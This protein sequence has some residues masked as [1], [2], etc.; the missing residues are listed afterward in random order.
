M[1]KQ[2]LTKKL[3]LNKE[4]IRV[5]TENELKVVAGATAGNGCGTNTCNTCL[6]TYPC[7]TNIV[8]PI[9]TTTMA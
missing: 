4:T 5:L 7:Y 8:E 2:E 3:T 6:R 1:M 9:Q